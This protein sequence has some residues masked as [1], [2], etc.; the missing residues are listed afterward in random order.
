MEGYNYENENENEN[1]D[2][3]NEIITAEFI[4]DLYEKN[5]LKNIKIKLQKYI[6]EYDIELHIDEFKSI[7]YTM[8]N[9]VIEEFIKIDCPLE[10][11][12]KDSYNLNTRFIDWVYENTKLGKQLEYIKN[13][14]DSTFIKN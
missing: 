12:N 7:L 13:I 11:L 10:F 2:E 9:D 6:E 1:Y 3:T 4:I 5:D 8:Y 14:Y